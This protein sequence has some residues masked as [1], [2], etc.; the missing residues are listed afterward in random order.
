[1][2]DL[3]DYNGDGKRD[4]TET[5]T[6]F[7]VIRTMN[8]QRSNTPRKPTGCL[9]DLAEFFG[10]IIPGILLLGL[11]VISP[12]FLLLMS[13]FTPEDVWLHP[14][15]QAVGGLALFLLF[16]IV[17]I[18]VHAYKQR[19]HS[20]RKLPLTILLICAYLLVLSFPCLRLH[21]RN[22]QAWKDMARIEA[23]YE[24]EFSELLAQMGFTTSSIRT[25]RDTRYGTSDYPLDSYYLRTIY[26][27]ASGSSD[28]SPEQLWQLYQ[29][30]KTSS[31][32]RFPETGH[33][34]TGQCY[35]S[36]HMAPSEYILT[37]NGTTYDVDFLGIYDTTH[38][39]R[40]YSTVR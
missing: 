13:W 40:I 8:S 39:K 26:A 31:G 1:M 16:D 17:Y 18:T 36:I 35:C 37:L 4:A 34:A 24:Q 32:C 19:M 9:S 25:E 21:H 12:V 38:R 7:A 15:L 10:V 28:Y 14:D 29:D 33:P 3:F 2:K 23:S 27:A 5:A 6:M 20:R 22:Q 30:I 11:C